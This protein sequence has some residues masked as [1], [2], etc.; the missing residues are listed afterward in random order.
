MCVTAVAH[1]SSGLSRDTS[2]LAATTTTATV[3]V[4]V[5]VVAVEQ[6]ASALEAKRLM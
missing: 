5:V 1:S 2:T 6:H 3:A 4:V